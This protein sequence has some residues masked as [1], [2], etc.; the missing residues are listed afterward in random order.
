MEISLAN[1]EFDCEKC[2]NLDEFEP[3]AVLAGYKLSWV[4]NVFDNR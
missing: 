4:G 2:T 1:H 3:L